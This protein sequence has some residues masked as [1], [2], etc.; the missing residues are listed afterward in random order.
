MFVRSR[1][2]QLKTPEPKSR[3]PTEKGIQH[4]ANA[5]RPED[6]HLSARKNVGLFARMASASLGEKCRKWQVVDC[7]VPRASAHRSPDPPL[8]S[9]AR[10]A[11]WRQLQVNVASNPKSSVVHGRGALVAAGWEGASESDAFEDRER[12]IHTRRRST[13]TPERMASS[14]EKR[15]INAYH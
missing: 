2:V 4:M 14:Y 1:R 15:T 10:A 9:A 11:L 6:S 3:P 13:G 7:R 5:L 8:L 12:F